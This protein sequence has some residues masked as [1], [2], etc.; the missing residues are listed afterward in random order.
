M[1]FLNMSEGGGLGILVA[2]IIGM[3]IIGGA[4]VSLVI[5]VIVK[6]IYES[7]DN[8]K[9]TKKQFWQTSLIVFLVCG[10]ISGM[11]CGGMFVL[12]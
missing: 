2:M 4:L 12:N 10:L 3:L 8:R 11:M 9:F 6:L 7:K 1:K 5:T